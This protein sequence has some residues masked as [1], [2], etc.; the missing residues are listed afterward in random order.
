[1]MR[2]FI[3]CMYTN[4]L[5]VGTF[6]TRW[7]CSTGLFN[8]KRRQEALRVRSIPL[9][10]QTTVTLFGK[11]ADFGYYIYIYIYIFGQQDC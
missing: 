1:M 6:A 4:P 8:I 2:V 3:M 10:D 11:L 9:W 7:C 5:V